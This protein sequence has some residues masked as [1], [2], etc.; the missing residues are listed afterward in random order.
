VLQQFHAMRDSSWRIVDAMQPID[1]IQQQLREQ[2]AA[3]I[4]RCQQGGHPVKRLWEGMQEA[5][6]SPLKELNQ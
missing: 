1:A 3:L 2:A 5:N 4:A 6:T